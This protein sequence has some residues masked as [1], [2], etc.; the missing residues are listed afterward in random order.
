[1]RNYIYLSKYKIIPSSTSCTSYSVSQSPTAFPP[2]LETE[3]AGSS[4]GMSVMACL[5][6][7]ELSQANCMPSTGERTVLCCLWG[8]CQLL[9]LLKIVL[10][11]VHQLAASGASGRLVEKGHSV[12]PQPD[13]RWFIKWHSWRGR[14]REKKVLFKI[15][16]FFQAL[17]L[18][19]WNV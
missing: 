8:V 15:P 16:Y 19:D 18:S 14:W 5:L 10:C 12:T 6:G 3:V 2:V 4:P 17:K 11:V 9:W 13:R 1:M 7:H